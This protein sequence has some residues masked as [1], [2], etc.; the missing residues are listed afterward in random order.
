AVVLLAAIRMFLTPTGP[1]IFGAPNT[2]GS[3]V[4]IFT[5]LAMLYLLIKIPMWGRQFVLR[6]LGAGRGRG[7]IGQIIHTILMIK[8]VGA[9]AKT[10]RGT[11]RPARNGR[12]GSGPFPTGPSPAPRRPTPA[13][14]GPRP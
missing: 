5:C 14:G 12:P 6:P 3:M 11:S 10:G 1:A 8:T 2:P 9:L 13:T 7:L 4:G